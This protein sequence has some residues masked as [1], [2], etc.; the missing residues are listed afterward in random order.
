VLSRFGPL[1]NAEKMGGDVILAALAVPE[2]RFEDVTQIVNAYPEVAHNYRREHQFNMWF[3]LSCER[4]ERI[5]EVLEEIAAATG[6][7]L[8]DLP[9]EEEY[10]LELK[11]SA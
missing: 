8:I 11:L 6:L 10:F 3:V 1:F 4:Q 2:E 9:K 5:A 7:P